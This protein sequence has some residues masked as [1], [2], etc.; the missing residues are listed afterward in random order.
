MVGLSWKAAFTDVG[1]VELLSLPAPADA[2][3]QLVNTLDWIRDG[4]RNLLPPLPLLPVGKN[5]RWQARRQITIATAR[6]DETTIYKLGAGNGLA[7][8]IGMDAPAQ[9]LNPHTPPGTVVTLSS[10][11]GG[12][13]GQIDLALDRI[14]QPTTMRWAASGKGMATPAGEPPAPVTLGLEA[15]LV[16]KGQ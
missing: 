7:V 2:N 5:A 1:Q 13:K 8:T 16:V 4:L 11:E 9:T 3:P 12:G 6:I 15:A 14:V 10:F